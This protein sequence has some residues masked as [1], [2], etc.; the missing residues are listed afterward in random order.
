M[1]DTPATPEQIVD[2]GVKARTFVQFAQAL[3]EHLET[4]ECG[5]KLTDGQTWAIH[6]AAGLI[7]WMLEGMDQR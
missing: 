1:C 6:E 4:H 7:R 5:D 2:L 3:A